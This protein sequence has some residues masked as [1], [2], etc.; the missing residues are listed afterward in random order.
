[1]KNFTMLLLGVSLVMSA[2]GCCCGFPCGNS[3]GY[4]SY[5]AC[6][7]GGCPG[8]ACSPGYP[9]VVPQGAFYNGIDAAQFAAAPAP[10]YNAMAAAP[11]AMMQTALAG[12]LDP[13][14]T[15]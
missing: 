10:T 8:G 1:M 12:P 14:P 5:G 4:A 15:Y 3:C 9:A 11:P 13:L 7:S 6:P 2:T